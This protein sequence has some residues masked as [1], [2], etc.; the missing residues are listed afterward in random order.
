[1]DQEIKSIPSSQKSRSLL[2]I[3]KIE[4]MTI[5][6]FSTFISFGS[7][8]IL[9]FFNAKSIPGELIEFRE[10]LL[11]SLFDISQSSFVEKTQSILF[12]FVA[13]AVVYLVIWMLTVLIVDN[14]NNYVIA[15]SFKHPDSFHHSEF[16]LVVVARI[17]TRLFALIIIVGMPLLLLNLAPDWFS[18]RINNDGLSVYKISVSLFEVIFSVFTTSYIMI[19]SLRLLMLRKELPF[20]S[21]N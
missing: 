13:G 20:E 4:L 16:W 15:N 18:S 12:W 11:D 9:F 1:M 2:F 17:L 5:L 8:L 19:I 21:E 10:N 14:Y 6:I 7:Y 3:S